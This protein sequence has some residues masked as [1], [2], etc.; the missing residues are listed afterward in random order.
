[1]VLATFDHISTLQ[2]HI[3]VKI[4]PNPPFDGANLAQFG[5]VPPSDSG[6]SP[7]IVP[8]LPNMA[9]FAPSNSD[10]LAEMVSS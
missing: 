5:P 4:G 3:L 7:Q 8:T 6:N 2:A 10:N 9:Q 1:M